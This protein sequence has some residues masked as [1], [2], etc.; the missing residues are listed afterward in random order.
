MNALREFG[1]SAPLGAT[2][3]DGGVNF[4]L[5]SRTA[6]GVDIVFFDREDDAVP[7][8]VIP[9]DPG[10]NR[11]YQYWH[12]FVPGVKSGQIYG[13]RV[14]GPFE[15]QRGLRFD[16]EKVLLDPYGRAVV[17]PEGYDRSAA[18]RPGDNAATA[19]KSAVVDQ[20]GYDWEGDI[21]L[22]RPA[23]Q[24]IIY[25][26][27]VKGFTANPNSGVSDDIRGTYAGVIEKIPYLQALGVTAVELLP[28]FQFDPYDAPI[29]KMNYWGYAPIGF[30]APH[31]Q[32][33]S[34]RSP[35][36]PLNEFRDMV[37]ALHRA[38]IEVILDVVF[39][40]TS[41][42]NERGPTTSFRGIDN[43]VYYILER[44][45]W[46]G[47]YTGCGNTLN[48]N[49]PIVRRMI[50]DSLKYW[51]REMHVDG[52]RFDLA[53]ILSRDPHGYPLP[54]PPVLWD[55]ESDPELAGTKL[56]AEAW[57][58]AGLYQVGSFVGDAWREWN[59]RFRDDVRDFFRGEPG[60]V[61][62][63]ADRL[64]GSPEIY[65][66]KGREM[67]QSINFVTCHDGF[68]LNDLV[69][70]NYKHN[71][72]NGEGN[73]DGAND[74]RSWNC[75]WEGPTDDPNIERLRNKQVKNFLTA[76]MLSLGVPMITMG[77][78]VRR[79]QNGNNNGFCQDN[80]ISWFDWSQVEKHADVYRFFSL[81]CAQRSMRSDRHIVNRVSLLDL[82]LNVDESWHGVRINQP[83]WGDNSHSLALHALLPKD[84]V[85]FHLM[86]NAYWEPLDFE[87]PQIPVSP[88]VRWID[89]SLESPHDIVP[90]DEAPPHEGNAYRVDA[91]SVVVLIAFA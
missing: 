42:G 21:P 57:D 40:H 82:L 80:E 79:T 46:Y 16:P 77:D 7:S 70:Y 72:A 1:L 33:S 67:E 19:M 17:V 73:R 13:Y 65:G 43:P 39:N 32:Y 20:S 84:K 12:Q 11:T 35:I 54:N 22:C 45:E 61:R 31:A 63:V 24:T 89:T 75:G 68:T 49:Q 58:A 83:D 81:L 38:G 14:S 9:I 69:S 78:E 6:T 52:F 44:G 29:G 60:S 15:P 90:Q 47:N 8:R 18:G 37:K 66:H 10:K 56:F 25:E 48:A 27:H 23:S 62:R 53:S 34:D 55:I 64:I 71:E 59:G 30:F 36:G 88:W 4:S 76:T 85:Y 3:V 91:R 50:V 87:L 86:L 28:V 26:M 2:V 5:F 41:E 51:V 74:N